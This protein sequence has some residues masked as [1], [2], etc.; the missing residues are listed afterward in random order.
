MHIFW[1]SGDREVCITRFLTHNVIVLWQFSDS[2]AECVCVYAV[3]LCGAH[4]IW[5]DGS[6]CEACRNTHTNTDIHTQPFSTIWKSLL[7]IEKHTS[8]PRPWEKTFTQNIISPFILKWPWYSVL[9]PLSLMIF[10]PWQAGYIFNNETTSELPDNLSWVA[11]YFPQ[12]HD[13]VFLFS[14]IKKNLFK[15][16]FRARFWWLWL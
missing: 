8:K 14:E 5:S 6:E 11:K 1:Y 3:W 7:N 4:G 13:Y 12:E 15:K 2:E 9:P 10:F 16:L